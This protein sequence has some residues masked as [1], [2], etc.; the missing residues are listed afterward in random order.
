MGA[1]SNFEYKFSGWNLH[2]LSLYYSL[3][4]CFCLVWNSSCVYDGRQ[5]VRVKNGRGAVRFWRKQMIYL[6]ENMFIWMHHAFL[7]LTMFVE[8]IQFSHFNIARR[9]QTD[10]ENLMHSQKELALN[11]TYYKL[12]QWKML[13]ERLCCDWWCVN[14]HINGNLHKFKKENGMIWMKW[15]CYGLSVGGDFVFFSSLFKTHCMVYNTLVM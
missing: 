14:L 15:M 7:S 13:V 9:L 3:F 2:F 8:C 5:L 11:R 10:V 1:L 4:E 6:K 12:T